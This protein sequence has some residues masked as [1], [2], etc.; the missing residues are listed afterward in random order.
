MK[1][2]RS[3]AGRVMGATDEAATDPCQWALQRNRRTSAHYSRRVAPEPGLPDGYQW[4]D[5]IPI[6]E[7]PG[8]IS[9]FS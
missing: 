9:S 7:P 2:Y 5:F 6:E 8:T 1:S 4:H 3:I